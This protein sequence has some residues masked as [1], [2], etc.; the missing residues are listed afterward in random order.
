MMAH[1]GALAQQWEVIARKADAFGNREWM[2]VGFVANILLLLLAQL[3]IWLLPSEKIRPPEIA[4]ASE[5]SFVEFEEVREQQPVKSR[6]FSDKIIEKEKLDQQEEINWS[7]AAD[8]TFDMTQRYRPQFQVN[9]AAENY[10]DRA[11]R[12]SLPAVTVNFTMLISPT[13]QIQDVRILG[14]RSDG[15]AHKPFEADFRKAVRDIILKQT[16]LV[17]RP[18]LVG[19]VPTQFQWNY[20]IKFQLR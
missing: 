20:S 16:K 12:S 18:Y 2:L 17:T 6:D 8:P 9:N 1:V 13:G 19:G 14:M 3:F 5:L 11:R 4:S 10:P 7:N 15:D